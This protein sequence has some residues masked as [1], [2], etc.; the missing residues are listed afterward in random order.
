MVMEIL[1]VLVNYGVQVVLTTHSPYILYAI[2][3]FLLAHQVQ[4][5]GRSLASPHQEYT[6]LRP[7]QVTAYCFADDGHVRSLLDTEV[8]LI[9]ADELENVAEDLGAEFS[10][11][12]DLLYDEN[13][14]DDGE[15]LDKLP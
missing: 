5:A 7:D 8:G 13:V 14:D 3:N 10:T 2:N 1:A 6:A 12:Q 9:D 15:G 4:A 11:L